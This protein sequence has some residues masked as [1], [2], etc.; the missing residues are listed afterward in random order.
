MPFFRNSNTLR[1]LL[2]TSH[3]LSVYDWSRKVLS[4]SGEFGVHEQG[5]AEFSHYLENSPGIPLYLV[6]DLAEEDFRNETVPHALGRDRQL[7]HQRKLAQ[8]F[9]T[10][11]YRCAK[12][13]GRDSQGRRDDK[14]LFSALTNNDRIAPWIN[15][16][17]E[18]RLPVKGIGSTAILMVF[19]ARRMQLEQIPHLLLVT[20]HQ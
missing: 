3:H 1:I 11:E 18:N 17:I 15:C 20:T 12:L 2:L 10:S 9:R 13:Q 4:P 19:L 5:V 16:I 7:L 14:V 6:A 8:L